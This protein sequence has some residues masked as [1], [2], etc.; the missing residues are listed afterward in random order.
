M[1]AVTDR[2]HRYLSDEVRKL[3]TFRLVDRSTERAK[4]GQSTARRD[5]AGAK[6]PRF[7]REVG[8]SGWISNQQPSG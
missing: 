7:V 1:R 5:Q 2:S 3:D 6:V 8:S 4:K